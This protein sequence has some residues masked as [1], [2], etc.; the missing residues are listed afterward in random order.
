MLTTDIFV[1]AGGLSLGK[2]WHNKVLRVSILHLTYG[3]LCRT[4]SMNKFHARGTAFPVGATQNYRED[5]RAASGGKI[6][7]GLFI[8]S[9]FSR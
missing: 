5:A 2:K 9:N 1:I 8:K 7:I 4:V 6:R 3:R